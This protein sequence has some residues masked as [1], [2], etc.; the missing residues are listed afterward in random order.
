VRWSR[1]TASRLPKSRMSRMCETLVWSYIGF[2]NSPNVAE[3][4]YSIDENAIKYERCLRPND[5]LPR[6]TLQSSN[7]HSETNNT[8]MV[9]SFAQCSDSRNLTMAE[10]KESKCP[11]GHRGRRHWWPR[12]RYCSAKGWCQ[13]NDTRVSIRAHGGEIISISGWGCSDR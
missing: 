2:P 9:C 10:R 6:V 3:S 7:C 4:G 8:T 12:C 13:S 1:E 5:K 11:C